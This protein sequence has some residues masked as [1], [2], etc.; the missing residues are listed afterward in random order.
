[1]TQKCWKKVAALSWAFLECMFFSSV[2]L[3]WTWLAIILRSDGYF[4]KYCNLTVN[5]T[6]RA[7]IYGNDASMNGVYKL[8]SDIPLPVPKKTKNCRPRRRNDRSTQIREASTMYAVSPWE[9]G[10]ATGGMPLKYGASPHWNGSSLVR[11]VFVE[12]DWVYRAGKQT[13]QRLVYSSFCR[14]KRGDLANLSVIMP[15]LQAGPGVARGIDQSSPTAAKDKE[16]D[17]GM[18]REYCLEQNEQLRLMFAVVIIIR[19]VLAFPLGI[20]YDKYGTTRTRLMTVVPWLVVPALTLTG[21]AGSA[22]LLTNLQ[23]ANL[24]GRK[25]HVVVSLYVGAAYSNGVI[26]LLMQLSHFN[27]VD[28][29]TS[30]MF[31]TIGIVPMLVST[32]AFLPK[33]RIPW[34]LPADYGKRRNQSLDEAMLRKQR[35]WQRRLS[36]AGPG[37]CRKPPPKF[38]PSAVQSLF[39]W[40]VLWYGIQKLQ[41]AVFETRVVDIAA[42]KVMG[43]LD[44]EAYFGYV[45]LMGAFCSPLAGVLIDR[46]FPRDLGY[47]QATKQMQRIV[48]AIVATSCLAVAEIVTD[49]FH[50]PA[51][52]AVSTLFNILHKVFT[53]TTMCAFVM[54]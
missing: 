20:F 12:A 19:D 15:P 37:V 6:P 43:P 30:F 17:S 9:S 26:A 52:Q 50:G 53:H 49:M 27:G 32:V 51:P 2:V 22:V 25:R 23:T 41:E 21:V 11:N 5:F 36:E 24:F 39:V 48:P 40:S 44:F 45:Q 4:P 7:R 42:M 28:I 31:L 47:S 14:F 10:S 46:Y 18:A 13:P 3:G 38:W 54:H 1:M 29:Q 16:V 34:P 33:T 8:D 35:A